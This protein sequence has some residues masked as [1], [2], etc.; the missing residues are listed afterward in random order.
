LTTSGKIKYFIL[1]SGKE[2]FKF[3]GIT[4]SLAKKRL[5]A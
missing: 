4:Q 2:K 1:S 3:A 5:Q